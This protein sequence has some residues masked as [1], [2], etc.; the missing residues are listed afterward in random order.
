MEEHCLPTCC[1]WLAQ[2]ASYTP[3]DHLA[4]RGPT[5]NGLDPP[6]S[7]INQETVPTGQ[8]GVKAVSQGSFFLDNPSLCKF[9]EK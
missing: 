5:H 3:Q 7:N 1:P 6:I 8:S 2:F 4:R 9:N